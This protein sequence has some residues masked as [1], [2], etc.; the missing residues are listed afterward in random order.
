MTSGFQTNAFQDNA[1]QI[2][3]GTAVGIAFGGWPRGRE[4]MADEL[5]SYQKK[6]IDNLTRELEE[7]E[8]VSPPPTPKEDGK[9]KN[10][11]I[12]RQLR[13]ELAVT[14]ETERRREL[15]RQIAAARAEK[16]R[17]FAL[18]AQADEEDAEFILF[19]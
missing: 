4:V 17:L 15:R 1:F 5:W 3:P 10:I 8:K 6:V 9:A 2:A 7:E 18:E 16:E 11:A 12:I 19:N 13:A 14:E